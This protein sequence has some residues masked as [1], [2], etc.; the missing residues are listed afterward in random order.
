MARKS[1]IHDV[2][3][4][5]IT[6]EEWLRGL[7][8]GTDAYRAAEERFLTGNVGSLAQELQAHVDDAEQAKA[9]NQEQEPRKLYNPLPRYRG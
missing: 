7:T 8:P 9:M 4:N 2:V 6:G 3:H 5:G 1:Q